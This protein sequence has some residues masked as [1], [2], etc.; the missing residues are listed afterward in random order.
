[1]PQKP[2]SCDKGRV[3]ESTDRSHD[4]KYL[5]KWKRIK[6]KVGAG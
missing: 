3:S 6:M 5:K 2:S 4:L 1:M